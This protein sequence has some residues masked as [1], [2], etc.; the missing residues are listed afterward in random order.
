VSISRYLKIWPLLE[1]P[2][3]SLVFSTR[4]AG[5]LILN[6]EFISNLVAGN[7]PEEYRTALFQ[8][9]VV[10]EDQAQEQQVVL[11]MLGEINRLTP[12]FRAS[13]ILTLDCNFSCRYC[14]EGSMKQQTTMTEATAEQVIAFFKERFSSRGKSALILDLYGG[15]PLMALHRIKQLAGALKPYVEG[16]GG[17]FEMNMVTN[18]SLLKPETLREL[19]GLGLASIKVTLDGPPENHNQ[20]RPFKNGQP[21]FERIVANLKECLGIVP[22]ILNGNYTREN[23]ASYPGLLDLLL[24][25]GF[26]KSDFK[27]VAFQPVMQ[28]SDKFTLPG[29][30]CGYKSMK[31]EWLPPATIF[32]RDA[33][34]SRDFPVDTLS[35]DVCMVDVEDGCCVHYD[36]TIYKC[37]TMAGHSGYEA[38]DV[39]Q[40]FTDF[41]K[42]YFAGKFR[43]L[44]EQC[45]NC[46]YLPLCFGGCR[47]MRYQETGSMAGIDCQK[48]YY[49][50]ALEAIIRQ[51]ARA[52]L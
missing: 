9:G 5:L 16:Q 36:G 22:T 20:F 44:E 12:A 17:R 52:Y 37:T 6:D 14:Y 34:I 47:Y 33:I 19:V 25:Q 46:V 39:W 38:G 42:P 43:K 51:D 2:G 30:S 31:E 10:V 49:D 18:G 7:V 26:T 48:P 21:S 13:I 50:A 41:S 1:K 4:T 28:T 24:A 45:Q 15:E 27:H 35:P 40:G 8:A 29:F 3:H 11:G 23:Y 32:T